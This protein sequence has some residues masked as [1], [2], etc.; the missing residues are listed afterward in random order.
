MTWRRGDACVT[1]AR[2]DAAVASEAAAVVGSCR[3][4]LTGVMH[5]GAVLDSAVVSNIKRAA[6]FM[7]P[8][9]LMRDI[10]KRNALFILCKSLAWGQR[11]SPT[12]TMLLLPLA[13]DV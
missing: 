5:A 10:T 2:A 4:R 11:A 8:E 1:T 3:R 9:N 6:N 13:F 7:H 12:P